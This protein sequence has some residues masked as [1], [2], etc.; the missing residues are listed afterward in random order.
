MIQ[1]DIEGDI[2]ELQILTPQQAANRIEYENDERQR[3]AEG[4][5]VGGDMDDFRYLRN[6]WFVLETN[7][8]KFVAKIE[9]CSGGGRVDLLN[10]ERNYCDMHISYNLHARIGNTA[11]QG[12]GIAKAKGK[13]S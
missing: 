7:H 6:A 13:A 3:E 4:A 8:G 10:P 12:Q 11:R 1:V 5:N 2:S 9:T